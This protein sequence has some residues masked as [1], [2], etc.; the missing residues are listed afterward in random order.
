[1]DLMI[2]V[3]ESMARLIENRVGRIH[4]LSIT[5][6]ALTVA[7]QYD[8]YG[9]IYKTY[10]MHLN[11]DA[12]NGVNAKV[13]LKEVF[14]WILAGISHQCVTAG[15]HTPTL[16]DADIMGEQS[17]APFDAYIHLIARDEHTDLLTMFHGKE[18]DVQPI[19]RALGSEQAKK[20][21]KSISDMCT[22]GICFVGIDRGEAYGN[23]FYG[24]DELDVIERE[25][26]EEELA[27]RMNNVITQ[28]VRNIEQ[29]AINDAVRAE[30]ERLTIR[31]NIADLNA[32]NTYDE[33]GAEREELPDGEPDVDTHV[34]GE[35][36]DMDKEFFNIR[37]QK[38][39]KYVTMYQG[40]NRTTA[41]D[42]LL[43]KTMKDY[44]IEKSKELVGTGLTKIRIRYDGGMW[45]KKTNTNPVLH[46]IFGMGCNDILWCRG[47]NRTIEG[48]LKDNSTPAIA[49]SLDKY[50]YINNIRIKED[51]R[52]CRLLPANRQSEQLRQAL[53]AH[54]MTGRVIP[55]DAGF[56]QLGFVATP[57][58]I[59]IDFKDTYIFIDI[60][61][62]S[63]LN[64]EAV[65]A[66]IDRAAMISAMDNEEYDK[67]IDEAHKRCTDDT[68]Q[69]T[70]IYRISERSLDT[71]IKKLKATYDANVNQM[72]NSMATYENARQGQLSTS[73]R[74]KALEEKD[75]E[76]RK[77]YD[78][79]SAEEIEQI[80]SMPKVE[81]LRVIDPGVYESH[82]S[83]VMST[84]ML[85]CI[86]PRS[87]DLHEIGKFD[88][89][90]TFK[91]RGGTDKGGY[92]FDSITYHNKTRR[93]NGYNNK[94]HAPHVFPNGEPCVGN[95]GRLINECLEGG[96]MVGVLHMMI[97]F[98]QSVNVEDSAG[99]SIHHWPVI[100][101]ENGERKLY[102]THESYLDEDEDHGDDEEYE[103]DEEQAMQVPF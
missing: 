49:E 12:F 24:E 1:M 89:K 67:H 7:P 97:N 92:M 40:G 35:Q 53:H 82:I 45:I 4:F 61:N 47:R 94:M 101:I 37:G 95:F 6:Q 96:S 59:N 75:S 9:L 81:S 98:P 11:D 36:E 44:F 18:E 55:S 2:R 88:I 77:S 102:H 22:D 15:V 30:E 5:S 33:A 66:A 19:I 78:D 99:K 20:I 17:D 54:G 27:E 103:D 56:N 8:I 13:I 85:D 39:R 38:I 48:Y 70:K 57:M 63:S 64:E 79:T 23:Q 87:G 60:K 50:S 16:A 80:A 25:I 3:D 46:I 26:E 71:D 72:K 14:R 91:K 28:T 83:V 43:M 31:T 41:S 86:D 58:S 84:S 29:E 51:E 73:L 76:L 62:V 69:S 65:R 74:L 10:N 52:H 32:L 90:A 21:L 93:V 100:K 42:E 68:I 34:E